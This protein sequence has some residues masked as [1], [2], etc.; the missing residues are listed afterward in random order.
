MM[1]YQ[2]GGRTFRPD[3]T[4]FEAA[5][6]A[7]YRGKDRPRCLCRQPGIEMYVARVQGKPILKRMPNTGSDHNPGSESYE[8]PPELS[9]IGR[10]SCR[11]RVS[12]FMSSSGVALSFN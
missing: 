10:A 4:D 1:A 2:V 9:E 7:V 6:A 11:E 8:P 5:L 3:H 12:Q